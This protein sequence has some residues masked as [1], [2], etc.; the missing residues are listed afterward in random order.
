MQKVLA[1]LTLNLA[2][3]AV[4]PFA[5]AENDGFCKDYAKVAVGQAEGA[6]NKGCWKTINENKARWSANYDNHYGWCRSA[7]HDAAEAERAARHYGQYDG[8]RG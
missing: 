8:C 5:Y 6:R 7:S 3:S 2:M 4:I 1:I